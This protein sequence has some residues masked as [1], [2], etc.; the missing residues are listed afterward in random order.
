M[1]S[2]N[3]WK[4]IVRYQQVSLLKNATMFAETSEIPF[5]KHRRS[6]SSWIGF[7]APGKGRPRFVKN[8]LALMTFTLHFTFCLIVYV[9]FRISILPL[10]GLNILSFSFCFC[11]A[12]LNLWQRA[13]QIWK[14][15]MTKNR[16]TKL[17]NIFQERK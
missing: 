2:G 17:V 9:H 15:K 12:R 3:P 1:I 16:F 13:R 5:W 7:H 4:Y 8:T 11:N 14:I 6:R 10:L